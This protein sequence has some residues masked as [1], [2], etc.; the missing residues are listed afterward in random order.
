MMKRLALKYD[1]LENV[2]KFHQITASVDAVKLSMEQNIRDALSH[3]A[4]MEDIQDQSDV[5]KEQSNIFRSSANSLKKKMW[6]KNIKV[7][8]I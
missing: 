1:N 4:R 3:T 5:L 7:V 6:C 2:S 8:F